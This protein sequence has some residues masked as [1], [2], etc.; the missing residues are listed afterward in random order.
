MASLHAPCV[1]ISSSSE[2][3]VAAAQ[4]ANQSQDGEETKLDLLG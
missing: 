3:E 2:A 4:E 1:E